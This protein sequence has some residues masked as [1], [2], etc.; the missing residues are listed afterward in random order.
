MNRTLFVV[1]MCNSMLLAGPALAQS[2][3]VAPRGTAATRGQ[4]S[5]SQ[6]PT[7]PQIAA[8]VVA[9]NQADIDAGK[10]ARSRTK[11]PDVKG[12][13]DTMIRDHTA[14]N[15]QA[16][17][18]V[19]KLHVKPEPSAT[20]K[21][22]VEESHENIAA[23]KKLDGA[24]FDKA[25]VDHEVT[26]HQQV[27]DAV[28]TTLLP[29]AKN[30]QLKGLLEKAAPVFQAHLDHARQLQSQLASGTGTASTGH[31]GTMGTGSGSTSGR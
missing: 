15:Q 17:A 31:T 29:N 13:A 9:A 12:F 20:S 16:R 2:A 14:V 22:L 6:G 30:P 4:D 25:Y 28:N 19:K 7:D 10:L 5:A 3:G 26:Y 23:L 27:I 21:S 11:N 8:I 18:L 1:L 24:A